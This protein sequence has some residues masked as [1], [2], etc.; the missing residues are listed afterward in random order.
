MSTMPTVLVMVVLVV[1]A[2]WFVVQG[3]N[4]H[5]EVA[6][7]EG[8]F[9]ALLAAEAG[10]ELNTDLVRIQQAPSE[11][12]R[13]ELVGVGKILSGIFVLLFAILLAIVTTPIRLGQIIRGS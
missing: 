4:M 12:M 11:L 9:H 8:E 2:V 6:V 7:Q 13:L 10:S 1:I 3:M 5:T